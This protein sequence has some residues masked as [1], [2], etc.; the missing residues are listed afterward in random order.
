MMKLTVK[1]KE[2]KKRKRMAKLQFVSVG[3]EQVARGKPRGR[4]PS[5]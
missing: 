3:W 2:K 1:E 5:I 4:S